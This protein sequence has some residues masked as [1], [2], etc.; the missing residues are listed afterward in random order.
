MGERR[1]VDEQAE[2]IVADEEAELEYLS[3]LRSRASSDTLPVSDRSRDSSST[4]RGGVFSA[5]YPAASAGGSVFGSTSSVPLSR[6]IT[7]TVATQG[8]SGPVAAQFDHALQALATSLQS[9]QQ[10]I[11]A[12]A[13][14]ADQA[15]VIASFVQERVPYAGASY[16]TRPSEPRGAR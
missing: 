1:S 15:F 2:A 12:P 13:E 8:L 11:L 6:V 10:G 7:V 16:V 4:P 5:S 14:F 3:G 9:V